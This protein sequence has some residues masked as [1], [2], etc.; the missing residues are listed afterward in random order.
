MSCRDQWVNKISKASI[1][2]MQKKK[3]KEKASRDR[4]KS[5]AKGSIA[6]LSV[7]I[8]EAADLKAS[9]PNGI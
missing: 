1:S 9:N 6:K 2:Y 5:I 7:T 3:Q 8:V 4:L